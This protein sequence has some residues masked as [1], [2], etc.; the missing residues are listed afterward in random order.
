MN[1]FMRILVFFD[2][3][4]A[5]KTERRVATQFRN[6]L[7]K[8]GYHMVQFSVYSRVCNGRDA[9][10]KHKERIYK[11]VPDNGSVRL[12]VITEKQYEAV[13]ILVGKKAQDDTPAAYEQLTIY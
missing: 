2:L 4:V 7:L 12:M 8:D 13:E 10:Q 9:V 1:K 6:F 5:T 11:N 3:P